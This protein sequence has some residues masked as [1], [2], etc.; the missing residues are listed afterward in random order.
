[1]GL[2]SKKLFTLRVPK[3]FDVIRRRQTN[4]YD[5]SIN[6]H[7]EC[8][9]AFTAIWPMRYAGSGSYVD[10]IYSN[11][12]YCPV[13][14]KPISTTADHT[15]EVHAPYQ[16]VPT[17]A[18]LSIIE[19]QYQ[20]DFEFKF[21]SVVLDTDFLDIRKGR[22]SKRTDII[23]F[24]FKDRKT[25]YIRKGLARGNLTD[26]L[27]PFGDNEWHM[28]P[29][30]YL[31]IND[32][33]YL[34]DYKA[35]MQALVRELKTAFANKLNKRIGYK[36]HT[37]RQSIVSASLSCGSLAG[38]LDN[39]IWKMAAPDGPA[40]SSKIMHEA[41]S[42]YRA[43]LEP[44][45][46]K[47]IEMTRSGESFV[48]AFL[49]VFDLK[50]S[51]VTRRAVHKRPFFAGLV[52]KLS[53]TLTSNPN[54]EQRL[55]EYFSDVITG[56]YGWETSL[57]ATDY[58]IPELLRFVRVLRA[59]YGEK[60]A[61]N[62]ILQNPDF[63]EV[64][65]TARIYDRLS[66]ENR[67]AVWNGPRIQLKNM[68]DELNK[69]IQLQELENVKVQNSKRY[70]VL[71]DDVAGF[72]FDVPGTTHDIAR[73]GMD[74]HNCVRTYCD[75]VKDGK[76]AIVEV[77]HDGIA[78]ACLEINPKHTDGR[79]VVLSQAKLVN[80]KKAWEN[81]DIHKAIVDWAGKHKLVLDQSTDIMVPK[82]GATA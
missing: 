16:A 23:R 42:I 64:K 25:Y 37:V 45:M 21:D 14:G 47:L 69:R 61:M 77:K 79:F 76:T 10:P 70:S 71:R 7:V 27:K 55:I 13:C 4:S 58:G 53:Q 56:R 80:N 6:Y 43:D 49:D 46:A 30:S 60:A 24:D 63:T 73:L 15:A 38:V 78:V 82:G 11:S 1:M 59:Q 28:S 5:H 48:N 51:R 20:I 31:Y 29:F 75:R 9:Q 12:F 72:T 54:Y 62:F 44:N 26:E 74:L 22:K 68:H 67:K 3:L 17:S 66:R 32:S 2:M 40:V 34:G 50:P 8:Q 18:E 41:Y 39:L 33:S 65:D 36:M 19:R 57:R 52:V 35:H 81:P